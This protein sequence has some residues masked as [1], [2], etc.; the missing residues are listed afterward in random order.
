MSIDDLMIV[1]IIGGIGLTGAYL[2]AE[3]IS[4]RAA[5]AARR[6]HQAGRRR[7]ALEFR[8]QD[9]RRG[10]AFDPVERADAIDNLVH[11]S[12]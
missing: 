4:W 3:L 7:L 6:A 12:D 2:R 9:D 11:L 1:I 8:R 5:N 10:R